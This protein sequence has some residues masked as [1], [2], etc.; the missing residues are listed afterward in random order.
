[1]ALNDLT[2]AEVPL[3]NY[4]LLTLY[5]H[6]HSNDVKQRS[7]RCPNEAM[8]TDQTILGC[9]HRQQGFV[10]CINSN[11]WI[12]WNY[13]GRKRFVFGVILA[14]NR[15]FLGWLR[16]KLSPAWLSLSN[17]TRLLEVLVD[18]VPVGRLI[19]LT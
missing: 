8:W 15:M 6:S 19:K 12:W 11:P 13:S 14:G 1:M 5:K 2:C 18:S 16:W 17:G 4:S 9:H 3:R 10:T 7:K